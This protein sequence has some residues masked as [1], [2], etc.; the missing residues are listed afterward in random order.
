MAVLSLETGNMKKCPGF[1]TFHFLAGLE[2]FERSMY[3]AIVECP[4]VK[5]H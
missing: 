2:I 3:L 4:I 1:Y 5:Y